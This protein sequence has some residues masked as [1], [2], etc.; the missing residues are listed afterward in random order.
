MTAGGHQLWWQPGESGRGLVA[1]DGSIHT[2]PEGEGTHYQMTRAKGLPE[3]GVRGFYISPKGGLSQIMPGESDEYYTPLK[4]SEGLLQQIQAADPRLY[5]LRADEP[6]RESSTHLP[7]LDVGG[8]SWEWDTNKE[9]W[10]LQSV[11][12]WE[13]GS[14]QP[15]ESL[16]EDRHHG[17]EIS[18]DTV[19]IP[20]AIA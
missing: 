17:I 2:W 7:L 15:T 20:T 12:D 19:G 5:Q 1:P 16:D 18:N 11:N 10:V 8:K 9:E 4:G 14:T 6:A 3:G 13:L